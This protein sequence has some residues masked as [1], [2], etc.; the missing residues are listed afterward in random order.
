M[1]SNLKPRSLTDFADMSSHDMS[2]LL[3][4]ARE[5]QSASRMGASQSLRQQRAH[6]V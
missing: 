1:V 3:A 5:L 2:A 6:V 4:Q